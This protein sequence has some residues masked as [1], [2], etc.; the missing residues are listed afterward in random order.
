MTR[1]PDDSNYRRGYERGQAWAREHASPDQL[2]A[3]ER[4]K[5]ESKDWEAMFQADPG[6]PFTV[7]QRFVFQL[8]P[9]VFPEKQSAGNFWEAATGDQKRDRAPLAIYVWGFA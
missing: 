8:H 5:A 9:E 7:A 4:W 2:Q 6:G 1:Q 3:L